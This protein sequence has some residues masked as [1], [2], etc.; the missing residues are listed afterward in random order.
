MF[1]F[2]NLDAWQWIVLAVAAAAFLWPRKDSI[3][4]LARGWFGGGTS[5]DVSAPD[6]NAVAAAYRLLA[7]Y[8]KPETATALRAEI[9]DR[10]LDKSPSNLAETVDQPE[11]LQPASVSLE[12]MLAAF[13]AKLAEKKEEA[14]P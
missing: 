6:A 11:T 14:K 12:K 13:L 3:L 7:P 2:L 8:L 5:P 10:F 4:S 9:A 1:D